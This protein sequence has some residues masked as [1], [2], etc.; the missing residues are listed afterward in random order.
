MR[1]LISFFLVS[2]LITSCGGADAPNNNSQLNG[3]WAS[4]M[5]FQ[6]NLDLFSDEYKSMKP[7][8]EFNNGEIVRKLHRYTDT[9]CSNFG[10]EINDGLF[11]WL[12]QS[13]TIGSNRI[14][15]NDENVTDID[16]LSGQGESL[17]DIFLLKNSGSTL[18]FGKKETENMIQCQSDKDEPFPFLPRCWSTRPTTIDYN[19]YFS[20]IDE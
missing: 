4:S 2:L 1:N 3:K 13:Y 19:V 14:T 16:Y 8:V 11:G 17:P 7:V 20:K 6:I 15:D 9:E 18:Y 12:E 5:C 10:V